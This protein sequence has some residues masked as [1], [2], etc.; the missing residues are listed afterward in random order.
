MEKIY[1]TTNYTFSSS[2]SR[3]RNIIDCSIVIQNG[4]EEDDETKIGRVELNVIKNIDSNLREY[5]DEHS[6]ELFD[7]SSIL[8]NLNG[9]LKKSIAN[10]IKCEGVFKIVYIHLFGLI[11]EYRNKGIGKQ[12]MKDIIDNMGNLLT[13]F[14]IF[15]SPI[16]LIINQKN[17]L[18]FILDYK[19]NNHELLFKKLNKFYEECGFIKIKGYFIYDSTFPNNKLNTIKWDY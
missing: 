2:N 1:F 9:K 5:C 18:E 6:Q 16:D 15:P 17:D 3:D 13:L 14:V 4:T 19:P 10:K 8:F 12:V 11:K 7:M